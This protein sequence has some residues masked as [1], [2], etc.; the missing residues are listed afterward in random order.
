MKGEVHLEHKL[1]PVLQP[2]I[3]QE[4]IDAVTEVLRSGWLGLGPKTEQFEQQFAGYTGSRFSVALNSGTAALHLALEILGIGP[5]DEV[6]VP[7]MTFISTVHAV[8][9]VGATPV[10]ADIEEDSMNISVADIESKITDKT[11][12]IIV[13]HMGGHPCDM[14]AV[15]EL[16]LSKGIKVVEDAAHASG[17]E[18]KG[19][20]IGS[21]SEMT[22]FSFH[23]VKNLT[24]GEGGAITCNAEWMNRRLREK[25]WVGISRDTWIRASHEK[26]YAWQ[27]FVDQVGYKYHMNDLQAAIGLVQLKK[28]DQLNGRRRE[29][30]ER[31][32]AEL[33][34]LQW[35]ELPEE[36]PYA[37]SS[38]HLFQ[39]KFIEENLRDRMIT[40]LQEHNIATGVHYYPCHL[41][42]CY[43]H[44]KAIVP[45]SSEIW[46]RILTLPIHPNIT[47]EDLDR[48]IY[49]I[50]EF[51]P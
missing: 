34:D 2:C 36:K 17:A 26:V 4:E 24:S 29:I 49:R 18:Y 28:L 20:R 35:M 10:F 46:K 9:Y 7:S 33:K 31:Y 12:A 14:D 38:W 40:H 13:V 25:R 15:H 27:Y 5:G 22:C 30:A 1:I 32:Q 42:P 21:I 16:A 44:L 19:R 47:D 48:I 6:I 23:A 41:H 37:K 51:K 50:R 3:G 39:I 45:R 11:K 8:S 43:I